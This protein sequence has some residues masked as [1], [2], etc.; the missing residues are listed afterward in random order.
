MSSKGLGD[1][2]EKLT[3][4]LKLNRV[5][6]DD[7]GC[8]QRKEWLNKR[9]PYAKKMSEEQKGVWEQISKR[10]V[11]GAPIITKEDQQ[12]MLILYY[13]IFGTKRKPS[14]CGSCVK[15]MAKEIHTIYKANCKT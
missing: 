12:A 3:K 14:S 4:L 5:F 13:D 7:C 6:G 8:K 1:T 11:E 9:F 10:I 2:I 15:Q